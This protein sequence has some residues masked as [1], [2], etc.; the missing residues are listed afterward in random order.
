LEQI[1][2]KT[3]MP[4]LSSVADRIKQK[5]AAYVVRAESWSARLDK[6]DAL[7]PAAFASTDAAIAAAEADLGEMESDMRSLTNMGPPTPSPASEHGSGG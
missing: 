1:R 6:L 7:E 2:V 5:K 3:T 4:N